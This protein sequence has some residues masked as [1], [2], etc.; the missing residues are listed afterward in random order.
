MRIIGLTQGD[1]SDPLASSGLNQTVFS[2]LARQSQLSQVLDIRLQGWR[3]WWNAFLHWHPDRDRWREHFDLN[4][5]SFIQLSQLA[6]RELNKRAGQFDIILQ[7]KTLYSP[8]YP[9]GRWPYVLLLDNTYALTERY[10]PPW[11]PMDPS[12]K[13]RWLALEQETYQR[14]LRVF[15]RTHWVRQS[16]LEDYGLSEQQAIYAGTGSHFSPESVPEHKGFDDGR[17]ILF[18]GKEMKRKGVPTLLEAFEIVRQRLPEAR[19]VL[20]GRELATQAQGVEVLGKVTDRDRM[21]QLYGQAS[22]FVLPALFEP[23]ANVVTEAMAYRLP[24]IVTNAGGIAELV[25]DGES[26]YVIPP[27]RPDILAERLLDLLGDPEKRRRMGEQGWRR[28]HEELNWDCVADRMVTQIEQ[29]FVKR[30]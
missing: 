24:C 29:A 21:R 6:G 9:P 7:L 27:R 13:K 12:E 22:V 26:G 28:I 3:R 16:L 5:W 15:A 19:L 17:T 20:V 30:S 25:Q 14:A 10:Y 23:C 18:V 1:V 8:G 2:A 11:A 4:V